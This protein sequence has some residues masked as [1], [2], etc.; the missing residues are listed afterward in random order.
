[1]DIY[2]QPPVCDCGWETTDD[3]ILET[4]V[5]TA[6][7]PHCKQCD[8]I[9]KPNVTLFGETPPLQ[10]LFAAEY[11]AATCDLMLV[12]GSSLE[13]LPVA[14]FPRLARENGARLI[15]VNS[16]ETYIDRLADVVIRD[17]VARFYRCLRPHF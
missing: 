1:M 10:I 14:D 6:M 8:G 13:V 11:L 9:L 4:F 15:I 5:T 2:E 12:A 16:T 17:D 3:L 7:I